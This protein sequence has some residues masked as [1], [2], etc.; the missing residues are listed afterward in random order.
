VKYDQIAH[1]MALADEMRKQ[2]QAAG[3][4]LWLIRNRFAGSY[5]RSISRNRGYASS[6]QASAAVP[7]GFGAARRLGR[8]EW[9]DR[10]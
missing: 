8:Y 9:V 5:R 10:D 1:V 4:M 6:D 7:G 2:G 3:G